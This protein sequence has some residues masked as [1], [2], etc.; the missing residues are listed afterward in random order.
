MTSLA[1]PHTNSADSSSDGW[2]RASCALFFLGVQLNLNLYVGGTM[3]VP[4]Y[5]IL[6]SSLML[7]HICRSDLK[8]RHL[9]PLAWLI[10]IPWLLSLSGTFTA[11][12]LVDRILS[13][14]QF[15][16]ALICGY[17]LY[18]GLMRMGLKRTH[19][20]FRTALLVLI[21]GSFLE[22]YLGLRIL[23]DT[24]RALIY[25][26][27]VVYSADARDIQLFGDVRPKLFAS[28][29]SYLGITTGAALLGW[30]LSSKNSG[31]LP[32][33]IK[34]ALVTLVAYAI[35]RSGTIAFTAIVGIICLFF[36]PNMYTGRGFRR[37]KYDWLAWIIVVF[38]ALLSACLIALAPALLDPVLSYI[39]DGS[40]HL[41]FSGPFQVTIVQLTRSP[42]M[43][44]GIGADA[45][46]TD[47]V[48]QIYSNNG[49][50]IR[51][52]FFQQSEPLGLITNSFW[53][54]W[55]YFGL[56]GGILIVAMI[57]AMLRKLGSP[58]V[59]LILFS[60]FALWNN[61][62]GYTTARSWFFL[63]LL[64]ALFQ[65]QCS[66]GP[67]ARREQ[68]QDYRLLAR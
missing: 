3:L 35:I 49:I 16:T 48:R 44:V 41:R 12:L 51:Y 38:I 64:A 59:P 66:R 17:A 20:F 67:R 10:G 28:E 33:M 45:L 11:G 62:G 31:S 15:S 54:H 21:I 32:H 1:L 58:Y 2:L 34:F 6:L 26:E 42:I 39:N 53:W 24:V 56:V 55:I 68:N 65:L 13:L 22:S 50:F 8:R 37:S 18:L 4:N 60:T 46:L 23:S 19:R 29:P 57:H 43:G 9:G 52:P 40:F 30:A 5:I 63:F 61:F 25:P 36:V 27:R 47:L 7:L 14:V